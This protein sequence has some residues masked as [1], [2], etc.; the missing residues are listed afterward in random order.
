MIKFEYPPKVVDLTINNRISWQW[1]QW[2]IKLIQKLN[3]LEAVTGISQ[4]VPIPKITT[5][6]SNGSITFTNGIA[7]AFT[8]P[9]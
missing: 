9:T 5:T 3:T 7:T 2:L 8:N 4:T 1:N 6:G